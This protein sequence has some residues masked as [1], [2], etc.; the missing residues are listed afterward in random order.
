MTWRTVKY[1]DNIPDKSYILILA[2][3]IEHEGDL[4]ASMEAIKPIELNLATA[5]I[6]EA[7]KTKHEGINLGTQTSLEL[8]G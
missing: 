5:I 3:V 1:F 2:Q 6:K 4:I 7:K 8:D